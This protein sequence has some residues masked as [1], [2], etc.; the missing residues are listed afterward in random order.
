MYRDI[1]D[2]FIVI[3]LIKYPNAI[4]FRSARDS[5]ISNGEGIPEPTISFAELRAKL[6]QQL[7]TSRIEDENI[8]MPDE[9]IFPV[10]LARRCVVIL[11]VANDFGYF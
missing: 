4:K 3:Y 2:L 1:C 8:E 6:T 11:K 5:Q 9:A 10:F 7:T